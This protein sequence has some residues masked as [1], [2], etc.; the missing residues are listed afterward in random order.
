MKTMVGS[1]AMSLSIPG[2]RAPKDIDYYCE[3]K[4]QGCDTFYHPDLEKWTWTSIASLDELYTI[5]A[6]HAF[7]ELKNGSW[8]KHMYDLEYMKRNGAQFIP[9]LYGIL[10]P[11]WEEI[12]GKKH[13]DLTVEAKDFFKGNIDRRYEHDSLHETVRHYDKPLFARILKDGC[14]VAVSKAKF[15]ALDHKTKIELVQEEL[16][17]IALERVLIPNQYRGNIRVAYAWALRRMITSL[18]KGWFAQWIVLHYDQLRTCPLN[19]KEL[20]LQNKE[21]LIVL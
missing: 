17:V 3:Q 10:Y 15:D 11:I 1:L 8:N 4:I 13:V 16:Y 12:H 9:D 5:K 21:R 18:S 2:T 7:W 19:Y 20:H 14:T 6:S